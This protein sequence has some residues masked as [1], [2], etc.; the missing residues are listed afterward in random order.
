MAVTVETLD[1]LERKLTVSLPVA[2]VQK[3][4]EA[5]LRQQSKK[6][7]M[8]GFRPGKV[9]FNIVAQQYGYAIEQEVLQEKLGQAFYKNVMDAELRVAGAPSFK[10][11]EQGASADELLFD[12]EFEVFPEVTLGDLSNLE[13]ERVS[14]DVDE[15]AIDRTIEILRRQR[16]TF[17]QRAV[18]H[19]AESTDRATVDFEGKI[20]GE[21][22][23][24]GKAD[25]YAF[26]LGEGQMLKEFEDAV[27][28]MKVGETKTFQLNFPA[29][30]HGKDVAGKQADFLISLKK[31]E[32]QVLPEVN[33]E[34]AKVL[35][36]GEGTVEALRA[37]IAKNL[38]REVKQRVLNRNKQAALDALVGA[39]EL[40]LPKSMVASELVHMMENARAELR[41]RGIKDV[42]NAPIPED[43]FKP[44]AERRVRL[45]LIVADL[46]KDN[47]LAATQE[48]IQNY[49]QDLASSYEKPE[50]VVR[51]YFSDRKRVQEIEGIILEA[52]VTDFVLSKAKV[53]EKKMPFEELMGQQ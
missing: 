6:V 15:A 35:G 37:D 9:P 40:D 43:L 47:A 48:Q 25:D 20:D 11:K 42:E 7:K 53:T 36:V 32:A 19:P 8:Q 52:N 2:E 34:L 14:T 33:D 23:E 21:P 22:F 12:A 18:T 16:R 41:A 45:G 30:Y 46:V 49:V 28:G 29:D 13:V 1:K 38:E 51:W 4:V 44:Q 24:G 39:A 17:N 31:L 27:L 50:E 5:R 26:V 10:Q 3:E